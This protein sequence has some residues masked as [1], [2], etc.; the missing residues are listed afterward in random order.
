MQSTTQDI[1]PHIIIKKWTTLS[2]IN[3]GKYGVVIEIQA[4]INNP[5]GEYFASTRM[6]SIRSSL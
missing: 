5:L 3:G 4:F 2:Q 6:K 1:I